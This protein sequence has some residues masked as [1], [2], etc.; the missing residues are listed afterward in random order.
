MGSTRRFYS[1]GPRRTLI[2]TLRKRQNESEVERL[3]LEAVILSKGN[4]T[5]AAQICDYGS[6][7]WFYKVIARYPK[8]QR[9]IRAARAR[10]RGAPS[11]IVNTLRVLEGK[12][13][14][15]LASILETASTM[16]HEEIVQAIEA[17]RHAPRVDAQALAEAILANANNDG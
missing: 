17:S 11:W 12:S 10:R 9:A 8:V 2:G 5:L 7:D 13:M 3:L 4:L 16:S 6:R 14:E 1:K 15:K